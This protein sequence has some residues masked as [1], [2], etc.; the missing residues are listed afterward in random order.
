[1]PGPPLPEHLNDIPSRVL[2]QQT[3]SRNWLA[4]WRLAFRIN[5]ACSYAFGPIVEGHSVPR[6]KPTILKVAASVF[7]TSDFG[8]SELLRA[9]GLV[10]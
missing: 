7:V 5:W 4:L 10:W 9:V 6:F 2:S 1:M 3:N 8:I